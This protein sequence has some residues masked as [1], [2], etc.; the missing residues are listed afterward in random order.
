MAKANAKTTARRP[1]QRQPSPR[2]ERQEPVVKPTP[3]KA[4]ASKPI[5]EHEDLIDVAM[6]EGY[7]ID[8]NAPLKKTDFEQLWMFVEY[9]ALCMDDKASKLHAEAERVKKM[10][11][12]ADRSKAKRY[13]KMMSKMEELKAAL[14]EA[15]VNVDSLLEDDDENEDEDGDDSDE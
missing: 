12:A 4:R 10:G 15:G 1:A 5:F 9:K 14:E 6:P 8:A 2:Q 3:R 7:D 13:L 11:S